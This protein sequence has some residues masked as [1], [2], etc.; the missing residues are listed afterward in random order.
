MAHSSPA[1]HEIVL[2]FPAAFE[3]GFGPVW[4][5][6]VRAVRSFQNLRLPDGPRC[7]RRPPWP[8][9]WSLPDHTT[10]RGSRA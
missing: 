7:V 5:E 10:A 4:D 8:T 6:V 3:R 9:D 1:V 2:A